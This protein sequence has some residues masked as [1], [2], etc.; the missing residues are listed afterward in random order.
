MAQSDTVDKILDAAEMLFAE[1]GFAE[2]SLRQITSKAGVNL[3]AV[4]YHFGS[5]NALIQA[6]FA[7]FFNPIT[8]NLRERLSEIDAK[9]SDTMLEQLL[10][11]V[12]RSILQTQNRRNA[13]GLAVFMRLLGLAYTQSQGHLR[14]F[15]E[16]NYSLEFRE[17]M[18]L[19]KKATPHLSSVERFWRLQ[20]M[21]GATTFTMSSSEAL[22]SILKN[23]L[24][25]SSSPQDIVVE[26]VRFLSAG[27]KAGGGRAENLP[28][29]EQRGD[30]RDSTE[31][32]RRGSLT[33]SDAQCLSGDEAQLASD[34]LHLDNNE[35][36]AALAA[37]IKIAESKPRGH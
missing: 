6:V 8:R 12:T 7:R 31:S 11:V 3:A 32:D 30:R 19:L 36:S 4:N 16:Q 35:R 15:L 28:K 17:F 26:L 18:Q 34:E 10:Q 1:R 24:D 20:F 37:A 2:T 21:L 23:E 13:N 25:I 22:S 27:L 14:R 33:A 29:G 9:D 5:K